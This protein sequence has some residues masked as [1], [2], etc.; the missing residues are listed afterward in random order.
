MS[1]NTSC[2]VAALVLALFTGCGGKSEPAPEQAD[3]TAQVAQTV[4]DAPVADPDWSS[5]AT[6][7][8]DG[9]EYKIS[10]KRSADKDLPTL[11]GELGQPYYDNQVTIRIERDGSIFYSKTF[12]KEAFLDFLSEADRRNDMLLGIAYDCADEKGLRFGA[13]LGLP[14]SESG[15]IFTLTIT[16][17]GTA[18]IT[19]DYTQD[20]SGEE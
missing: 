15:P 16:T 17:D 12:R 4:S 1:K 7:E 20:T 3:S 8:I 14:G 19:K 9:H 10:V 11:K 6:E 13:Q 18:S 5:E 2:I